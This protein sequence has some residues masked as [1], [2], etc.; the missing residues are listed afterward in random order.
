MRRSH[1]SAFAILILLG[2]VGAWLLSSGDTE[3]QRPRSAAHE[4]AGAGPRAARVGGDPATNERS[5]AAA[6]PEK[7]IAA[8]P[9]V[10]PTPAG[11]TG[12]LR[13][14]TLDERGR[15]LPGCR[16]MAAEHE[17]TTDDAGSA[18]F[19]VAAARTFVSAEPPVGHALRGRSGW[20][21]VRADTT[22]EVTLV[23]APASELVFWCQLVAA[24]DGKPLSGVA[25]RQQ[26]GDTELR[27]DVEGFLQI[28]VQD[29]GAFLDARAAG[30]VPC[31]IVPEAGHEARSTALRVPLA[32]GCT[33]QVRTV[34]A[35]DAPV[36]GVVVKLIVMSWHLQC[37]RE[38]R[39][40]GQD[41][42]WTATSDA[43]GQLTIADLPIGVAV[44]IEVAP[45]PP[46][47]AVEAQ[48]W[49]FAGPREERRVVL[50]AAGAVRGM[51][52]DAA[53]AP[54]AGVDVHANPA[55]GRVMPRVLEREVDNLRTETAADGTFRLEGLA[56]GTW[57]VG[58]VHD[59]KLEPTSVAVEV[60][61]GRTAEIT[62]Q[63]NTGGLAV[64][65]RAVAADGS[66]CR[67][68]PIQLLIDDTFV[69]EVRTDH[70]GH[71]RFAH[72]PAGACELTTDPFETEMGLPEPV[73]VQAGDEQVELR[74]SPVNGSISGR[75]SGSGDVWVT[76]Y[77]RDSG[78]VLGSRCELDGTFFYRGLRVGTWDLVAFD[79]TVRAGNVGG[80]QVLPGRETAGVLLEMVAGAT[81]RPAHRGADEFVVCNGAHV[82]GGDSLQDGLHGEA[83]VP[84]GTWTVVFRQRGRE[85]A[86]RDVTVRAGENRIVDGGR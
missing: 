61:A 23:L 35:A 59:G 38:V 84:P 15:A 78:D 79:R 63:A 70:D 71:F 20:Q 51:V 73:T 34:D 25:L 36:A 18:T 21:T 2:A 49:S 62:L 76:A 54:V 7:A 32:N 47:A 37:P 29:D 31:R 33:L 55:A 66:P 10:A 24:E 16:V 5:L 6:E 80:V 68:V 9:A 69:A 19:E 64:G 1:A 4:A 27:S 58:L 82:A 83:R 39:P 77:R 22:T 85:V 13:V 3:P 48:R 57:W 75:S 8:T 12:Q 44:D 17:A 53:G 43:Q 65:G 86:R 46:F 74:M 56:P 60:A 11:P 30:R 40:R 52:T 14:I 41:F 42:Q 81:L 72:L 67:N 45:P 28:A 50:T 26:P